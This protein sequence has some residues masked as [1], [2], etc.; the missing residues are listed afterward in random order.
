[1]LLGNGPRTQ[2]CKAVEVDEE[3]E[4]VIHSLKCGC[5]RPNEVLQFG[6]VIS[7]LVYI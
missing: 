2:R 7:V 6:V 5:F 3:E 4:E 1:M